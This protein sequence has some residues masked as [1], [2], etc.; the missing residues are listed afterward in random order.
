MSRSAASVSSSARPLAWL[1]LIQEGQNAIPVRRFKL[2]QALVLQLRFG[3]TAVV[4]GCG[5]G[6]V[7]SSPERPGHDEAGPAW[8]PEPETRQKVADLGHRRQE[9]GQAHQA[10]AGAA[11]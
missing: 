3:L 4:S 11:G 1:L 5:F 10:A 7:S 6:L 8:R 9:C 2:E